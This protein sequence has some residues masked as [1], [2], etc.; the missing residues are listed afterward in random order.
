MR[1]REEGRGKR[2]EG[3]R[4]APLDSRAR[5]RLILQHRHLLAAVFFLSSLFPLPSSLRAQTH[6]VILSGIGAEP[7]YVKQFAT[8]G[9]TLAGALHTRFS[10]P[11]S[12]ILWLGEDSVRNVPWYRGQSTKVNVE[13]AFDRVAARAKPGEQVV[14]ILI[15]HGNG[16]GDESKFSMPG[17]DLSVTDFARF[18]GRF[19]K[20]RVAFINLTSASGDMVPVVS[21]SNRVVIAAT[22]T[23]FERNE[24]QFGKY[25]VDA[26]S[27]DGA[28]VDKDGHVSL[29]EAFDYARLETKRH[30]ENETKLMTEHAILDDDGDGKGDPEPTGRSGDGLLARRFFLD[31][32]ARAQR[33]AS[34]DP[35]LTRLY[36][37]RFALEDQ[38]DSL[39]RRKAQMT[40]DEF[41][42]ALEKLLLSLARTS[43]EIR[44][45]EGR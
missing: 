1:R 30:Y 33:A 42:A 20:Q 35:Q 36:A 8:L 7:K 13:K 21:A 32:G 4:S 18:L 6:V 9:E 38:V 44:K 43:R 37:D 24:S 31:A 27:Q 22:K 17:P 11:D 12:T 40:A 45:L 25:F 3:A 15:G 39:K 26:L 2:E 41:D 5:L 29:F 19:D 16:T 23:A 34:I 14:V 10:I 28:D